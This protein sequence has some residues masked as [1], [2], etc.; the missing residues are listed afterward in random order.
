[1]STVTYTIDL[2]GDNM[3]KIAAINQII[4]GQSQ[5]AS[6]VEAAISADNQSAE[7]TEAKKEAAAEAAEAAKAEVAAEAAKAEAST[8]SF[9]EFK[10]LAKKYKKQHGEEFCLEVL[11]D[12]GIPVGSSIARTVSK[13]PHN[14]YSTIVDSWKVGPGELEELEELEYE[15]THEEVKDALRSYAKKYGRDMTKSIMSDHNVNLLPDVDK[16]SADD[17]KRLLEKLS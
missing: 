10:E 16:L 4:L 14:L 9:T 11:S 13:V 15:I 8:M 1:M 3:L 7:Q 17:L 12:N 5:L 2:N 6:C